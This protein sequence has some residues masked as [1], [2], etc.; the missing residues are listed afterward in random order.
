MFIGRTYAEAEAPILWPP[1]VKSGLF[2]RDPNVRKDLRA[3]GEEEG[4]PHL[5][6]RSSR[7]GP[8][9]NEMICPLEA[10]IFNLFQQVD[11]SYQVARVLELQ[12]QHKSF[13]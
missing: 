8:L 5:Q 10:E 1:D 12:L 7:V 6:N 2:G 11:S 4:V 13:Q 9:I 3:G